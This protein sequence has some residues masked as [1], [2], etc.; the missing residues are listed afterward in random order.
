[1]S[2]IKYIMMQ[3]EKKD[4]ILCNR[5]WL[6]Y[7]KKKRI[8]AKSHSKEY[9]IRRNSFSSESKAPRKSLL[10]PHCTV[11]CGKKKRI[12]VWM[13]ADSCVN[14]N[15]REKIGWTRE[16]QTYKYTVGLSKSV[17]ILYIMII[18]L[19]LFNVYF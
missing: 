2:P 12:C 17:D 8:Y 1:M 15:T 4:M 6:R 11:L 5:M 7:I 16:K 14:L 19:L 10:S 9:R 3:K 13:N 18:Y